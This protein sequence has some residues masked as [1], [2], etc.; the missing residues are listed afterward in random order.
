M[1]D[2][3]TP[4]DERFGTIEQRLD[5]L[6]TADPLDLTPFATVDYVD[7]AVG[8]TLAGIRT[9]T[10]HINAQPAIPEGLNITDVIGDAPVITDGGSH[11]IGELDEDTKA[12]I[13]QEQ[14]AKHGGR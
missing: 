12:A 8:R 9:L 14:I 10:E 4:E 13:R 1:P 2:D 11:T 3:P 7:Q 6:E 5:K